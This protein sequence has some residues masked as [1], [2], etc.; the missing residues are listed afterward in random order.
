MSKNVKNLARKTLACLTA[1]A[2]AMT[3]AVATAQPA[4]AED[5]PLKLGEL[6]VSPASGVLDATGRTGW[7]TSAFTWAGQICPAG[8]RY[9]STFEGM[10]G[11]V[12]QTAG[13]AIM[14]DA[15][16]APSVAG[17][18]E[19]DANIYRVGNYAV[20]PHVA[21]TFPWQYAGAG[22]TVELRHTCGGSSSYGYYEARDYYYAVT[23]EIEPGGAW[24]VVAAPA[25]AVYD[26]AESEVEVAIPEE[27]VPTSPTGLKISVKPGLTTL[28]GPA[29]RLQG[30][31][32]Q[33]TGH[34]ADVTVN[35]DRRDP[36]AAAWTLNGRASDF[37]AAGVASP[38]SAANLGW[39]PAKVSGAGAAGAAVEPGLGLG[40]SVDQPLATG[41]ASAAEDVTTTV[42]AA[43]TLRVPG[44]TPAGTYSATLTLTLI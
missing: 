9:W 3:A 44:G 18:N 16:A 36:A 26:S 29:V 41:A 34:L 43:L 33:A 31:P 35:D 23:I 20:T 17:L 37:T 25:P 2:A 32:W 19:A 40:L 15:D 14:A 22:A 13:Y 12:R 27:I 5:D 11:G 21:S 7:I 24:H 42:N 6:Q 38:L 39:A 4:A 1:A 10:S 8:Y 28:T 30:Q